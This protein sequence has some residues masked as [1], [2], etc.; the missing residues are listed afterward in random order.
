VKNMIGLDPRGTAA[1]R[2]RA[3]EHA[4]AAG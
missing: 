4:A 1:D 2:Q 3:V